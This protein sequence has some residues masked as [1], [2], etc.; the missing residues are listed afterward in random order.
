MARIS[1][2]RIVKASKA[3]C[4]THK[5]MR[6]ITL[7]LTVAGMLMGLAEFSMGIGDNGEF[8]SIYIDSYVGIFLL[9]TAA[10]FSCFTVFE[11][12]RELTSRQHADVQISLPVSANERF[13]SKILSVLKIS[14]LPIAAAEIVLS[15]FALMI[16]VFWGGATLGNA[17]SA[18]FPIVRI[19]LVIIA[20]TMF[21]VSV[22]VFCMTC[23]GTKGEG[24]Y[25]SFILM[26]IISVL[27]Y[28][29]WYRISIT[30]AGVESLPTEPTFLFYWGAGAFMIVLDSDTPI[31]LFFINVII[32]CLVIAAAGVIYKK[33][34]AQ[35]AGKPIVFKGFFEIFMFLGIITV[36]DISFHSLIWWLGVLIAGI[37]S[38]IIR[39]VVSRAKLSVKSFMIWIVQFAASAGLF[40]L[41]MFAGYQ[42]EGFGIKYI[43]PH[44]SG[45]EF[46]ATISTTDVEVYTRSTNFYYNYELDND[47]LNKLLDVMD[48]Y[49]DISVKSNVTFWDTVTDS[50]GR[51]SYLNSG[52]DYFDNLAER[53][54]TSIYLTVRDQSTD[55][56]YEI[57]FYVPKDS[58]GDL[59]DKILE[60]DGFSCD[61]NDDIFENSYS[62]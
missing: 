44:F 58:T 31:L 20:L 56:S 27:P 55:E 49:K 9:C 60:I 43:S 33:R 2:S 25:T 48:E 30:F 32:S 14:V 35:A 11:V 6:F 34:D 40:F 59:K 46:T 18:F 54:L 26:F 10:F 39:I 37:I 42:T 28:L 8:Q 47:G 21:F 61:Q 7:L 17:L 45:S 62:W 52:I 50:S 38:M 16:C 53:G 23:C 12:F 36:C 3:E 13:L 24:I 29:M 41:I 51:S 15:I 1:W 19:Y 57:R 5:K 22:S 4:M